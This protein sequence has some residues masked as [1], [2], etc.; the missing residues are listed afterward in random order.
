MLQIIFFLFQV[1][2]LRIKLQHLK[3]LYVPFARNT[4][5][6]KYQTYAWKNY[7]LTHLH[8][9]YKH[10]IN[11]FVM[12]CNTFCN[13][14][15]IIKN[16]ET[17]FLSMNGVYIERSVP[18]CRGSTNSIILRPKWRGSFFVVAIEIVEFHD[19]Y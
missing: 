18:F 1:L 13:L 9:E 6:I 7:V 12:I 11:L 17:V 2:V 14:I 16:Q 15:L 19:S 8:K 3:M 4:G 10:N 5:Y